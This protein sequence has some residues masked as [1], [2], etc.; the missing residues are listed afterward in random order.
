MGGKT[1]P[2]QSA[3]MDG[4]PSGPGDRDHVNAYADALARRSNSGC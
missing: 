1:C 4:Y 2:W 3:D